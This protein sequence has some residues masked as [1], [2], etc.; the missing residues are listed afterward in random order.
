MQKFFGSFLQKISACFLGPALLASPALAASQALVIGNASFANFPPLPACDASAR[1]LARRLQGAGYTVTEAH[2][3][4]NGAMG[5]AIGR[6][7]QQ[8]AQTPASPALIYVCS[9]G[10]SLQGRDFVLPVSA[11]V[12]TPTDLMSEGILARN[13]APP[14]AAGR[15][16]PIVVA[17][18]LARDP[19][20]VLPAVTGALTRNLREPAEAVALVIE[21]RP[22]SAPTA[23]ASLLGEAFAAGQA[24][25]SL[26]SITGRLPADQ[27]AGVH[28]SAAAPPPAAAPAAP[29]PAAKTLPDDAAMTEA[30]RRD[31][32]VALARIGYYDGK[33]DG[34]FGPDTR[35]AIRRWQHEQ[36]G[37]MTGHLTSAEATRLAATSH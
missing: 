5:G 30:Q 10:A 17:L 18:D 24:V 2:D 12:A 13:F 4:T 26:S 37:D 16:A 27:V 11:N 15:S 8:A 23:F 36:G 34:V 33:L 1:M 7:V 29:P 22:P 9:Y 3:L 25:P 28:D 6:F 31:I 14:A 35:A 21:T 32:Q 20:G 19:S